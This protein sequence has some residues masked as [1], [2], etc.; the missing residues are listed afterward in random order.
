MKECKI[1]VTAVE[2]DGNWDNPGHWSMYKPAIKLLIVP[3]LEGDEKE[4]IMNKLRSGD[5]TV[6]DLPNF[7]DELDNIFDKD[8][9]TSEANRAGNLNEF[10]ENLQ[11]EVYD[12]T[13]DWYRENYE[14]DGD[15]EDNEDVWNGDGI[16]DDALS[17]ITEMGGKGF[18]IL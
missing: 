14:L 2:P 8:S 11:E 10:I 13:L 5:F 9:I 4:L 18:K 16:N 6:D 17:E 12:A 7:C 15:D 1:W 3:V